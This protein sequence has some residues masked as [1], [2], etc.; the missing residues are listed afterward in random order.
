MTKIIIG[1]DP[2]NGTCFGILNKEILVTLFET[3]YVKYF[4]NLG[5]PHNF[6]LDDEINYNS[7]EKYIELV[8]LI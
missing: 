8:S 6:L 7:N 2:Y 3:D 5:N 1:T 4:D